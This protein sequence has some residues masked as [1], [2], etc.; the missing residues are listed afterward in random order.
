MNDWYDEFKP[1]FN[2]CIIMIFS[3][4][5]SKIIFHS[6]LLL[7]VYSN[8]F[9]SVSYKL[10]CNY[11]HIML[12]MLFYMSWRNLYY[13]LIYSIRTSVYA[14]PKLYRFVTSYWTNL[15]CSRLKKLNN[16][17]LRYM[18]WHCNWFIFKT[19]EAKFK[20]YFWFFG[21]SLK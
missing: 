3:Y 11:W 13:S 15:L 16:S 19:I 9:S 1:I 5:S 12:A 20:C 21:W 4:L 18:H 7:C 6:K 8:E 17:R 10:I 2:G 14:M